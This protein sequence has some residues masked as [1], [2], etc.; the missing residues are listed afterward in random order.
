MKFC[1]RKARISD[2]SDICLIAESNRIGLL[3]K[4][5]IERGFL[6]SSFTKDDYLK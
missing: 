3:N 5:E 1:I 4:D 6:V 2:V